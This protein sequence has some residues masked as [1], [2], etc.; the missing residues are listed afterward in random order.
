[1]DYLVKLEDYE[2]PLDRLL[3]L[4]EKQEIDAASVSVYA[5]V[6]QLVAYLEAVSYADIEEGGRYLVLASTLLAIKAQTLMPQQEAAAGRDGG[7]WDES[8]ADGFTM[9]VEEEYL[10]I[11]EA[12]K[13]LEECAKNWILS[14]RRPVLQEPE[15]VMPSELKDDVARLVSAFKEILDRSSFEPGPYRVEMAVDFEA[16]M[17][18]VFEMIAKFRRGLL[19][20]RLFDDADRIEVIYRFLAILELVFLGRLRLNRLDGDGEIMLVAV[21]KR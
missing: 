15:Q 16:K 2:G 9:T 19:F 5:V 7:D 20:Q 14:Y 13:T 1:M 6:L 10:R 21:R 4:V 12:A 3:R 18:T 11:K 17:E 8:G